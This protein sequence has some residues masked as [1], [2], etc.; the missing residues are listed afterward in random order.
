MDWKESDLDEIVAGRLKESATLEY[1]DSRSLGKLES[2]WI[3]MCKDVSAFANSEG[4]IL[5]Y[6]IQERNNLPVA[7]DNGVDPAVIR[8]EWIE[9]ILQSH[10]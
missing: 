6:G 7:V 5:I 3:E 10:T 2:Q 9:D 8:K 4:G 1:K